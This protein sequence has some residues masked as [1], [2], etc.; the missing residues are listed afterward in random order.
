VQRLI[1]D[2]DQVVDTGHQ[3][4]KCLSSLP[5]VLSLRH[6]QTTLRD[7]GALLHRVLVD[8]YIR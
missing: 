1:P 3:V 6:S 2:V 8:F 7:P 4:E 5:L